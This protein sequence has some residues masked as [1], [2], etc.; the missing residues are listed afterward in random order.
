M[1]KLMANRSK[2][3][4]DTVELAQKFMRGEIMRRS[5]RRRDAQRDHVM[6]MIFSKPGFAGVIAQHVGLTHQAI[7]AWDQ[8]P[9]KYVKQIAPL[10]EMSPE[11]IRPDI[12][13]DPKPK[14]RSKSPAK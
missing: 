10:I 12:F 11:E 13:G 2:D 5:S 4:M 3:N 8:I 1:F 14:H 6:K 9:P 7:A